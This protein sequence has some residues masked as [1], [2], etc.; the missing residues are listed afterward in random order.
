MLVPRPEDEEH[1]IPTCPPDRFLRKATRLFI[2]D[3]GSSADVLNATDK[4]ILREFLRDTNAELEFDTA[5]DV[6]VANKGLR[7]QVAAWDLPSSQKG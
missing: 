4:S 6:A 7:A 1:G 5:N 2:I 3:S